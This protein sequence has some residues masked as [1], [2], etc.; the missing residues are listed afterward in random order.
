V[1]PEENIP[2]HQGPDAQTVIPSLNI[3]T[4]VAKGPFTLGHLCFGI[5]QTKNRV[6][7]GNVL[8]VLRKTPRLVPVRRS[9]GVEAMNSVIEITRDLGRPRGDM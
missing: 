2:S 9:E 4:L 6:E 7:K 3:T 5:V 8:E 1:V